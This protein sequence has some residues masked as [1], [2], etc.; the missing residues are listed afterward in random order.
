MVCSGGYAGITHGNPLS[1][2]N[3]QVELDSIRRVIMQ[4]MIAMQS[5]LKIKLTGAFDIV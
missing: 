2:N 3:N 1:V 5:K 4:W